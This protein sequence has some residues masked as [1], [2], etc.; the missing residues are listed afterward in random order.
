MK[1]LLWATSIQ[2]A[3]DLVAEKCSYNLCICYLY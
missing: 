1:P 2:E 3:Q